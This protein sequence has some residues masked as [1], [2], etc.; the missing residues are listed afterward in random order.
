VGK[1]SVIK[2]LFQ[3]VLPYNAAM[4]ILRPFILVLAGVATFA[5]SA[6]A[7]A[8]T[9]AK[10]TAPHLTTAIGG[11]ALFG[12]YW[13]V[14]H[15]TDGRGAGPAAVALKQRPTDLTQ[16]TRQN[17]GTFPEERFLKMMNGEVTTPAHGTAQMPIWGDDFRNTTTNTNVVQDRLHG[18][19]NYVEEL[20]NK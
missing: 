11:K 5:I 14:C 7:Q 20:Q 12:Q 16:L 8:A 18:L 13:A 3:V 10:T 4:K 9:P 2:L 1:S 19:L 6:S 17:S 15:G